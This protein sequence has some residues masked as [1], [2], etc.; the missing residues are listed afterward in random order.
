MIIST[1]YSD[2][3]KTIDTFV[4]RAKNKGIRDEDI[5]MLTEIIDEN[6]NNVITCLDDDSS[7]DDET[8]A[9][10][11][12]KE[13]V[14]EL[15]LDEVKEP[16]VAVRVNEHIETIPIDDQRFEDFAGALYYYSKKENGATRN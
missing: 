8:E 1:V 7:V 13:K 3:T 15:F 5:S 11:L 14:V 12:I 6:Y 9:I 2:W 10:E 16:Y 4:K